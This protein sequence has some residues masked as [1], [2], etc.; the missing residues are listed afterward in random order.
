MPECTSAAHPMLHCCTTKRCVTEENTHTVRQWRNEEQQGNSL[1]CCGTYAVC[2]HASDMDTSQITVRG[3]EGT[4]SRHQA[5]RGRKSGGAAAVIQLC[6]CAAGPS[7]N[8]CAGK[9][10]DVASRRTRPVCTRR[11][12]EGRES[13]T[14][15][16]E[17][18]VYIGAARLK[19]VALLAS[20][21]ART[22]VLRALLKTSLFARSSS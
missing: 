6:N 20:G 15:S 1:A 16:Y 9:R 2:A 7:R 3:Y 18:L 10:G 12:A 4:A 14:A 19:H 11:P 5:D 21:A 17:L 22:L 8:A 13:V